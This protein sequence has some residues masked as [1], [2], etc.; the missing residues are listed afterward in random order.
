MPGLK[1]QGLLGGVQY[2][3]GQFDDAR[4]AINLARTATQAGAL[5]VNYC[6]VTKLLHAEGRVCGLLA[7]DQTLEKLDQYWERAKNSTQ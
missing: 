7:Q 6:G 3:D 1:A 5:V 2:W 4:F